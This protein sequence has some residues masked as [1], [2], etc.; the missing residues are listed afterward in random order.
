MK[1]TLL[2]LLAVASF[3]FSMAQGDQLPPNGEAG[4]C[5]VKCITPDVWSNQTVQ[6]LKT[7]AYNK[8]TVGGNLSFFRSHSNTVGT[9]RQNR[10]L[11]WSVINT[12]LNIPLDQMRNWRDGRFTRNET[13]WFAFY[14]N[15]YWIT[16]TQ[17]RMGDF[18]QF[19]VVANADYKFTD[20][21]TASLNVGY[22]STSSSSKSENEAFK[23][24]FTLDNVYNR[25][26]ES[27]ASSADG[28]ATSS[29]FN[30]DFLLKFDKNLTED[31][32][33]KV[34][35]GQNIRIQDSKSINI[36]GSDLI[37]PGFYNIS[38]RTGEAAVSESS[39]DYRRVSFY[40]E[41]T[42]GYKDYLYL[43]GSDR[44]SKELHYLSEKINHTYYEG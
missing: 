15:P 14:Q 41:A 40:G 30:S 17:R 29:R 38:T 34:T 36:S 25:L 3:G 1:K 12:P 5:Y 16:D 33:L 32:N 44:L 21:L 23:Y 10:P 11:Y 35:T 6:V 39:T 26:P 22:T 20:W 9:G 18:N 37:I 31:I 42:V 4:K 2:S 7:P 28:S 13:S 19:N 8:L 27:G 43:I 24:A